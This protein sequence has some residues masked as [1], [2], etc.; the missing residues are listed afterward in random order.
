MPSCLRAR[1]PPRRAIQMTTSRTAG[2]LW[3]RGLPLLAKQGMTIIGILMV[4]GVAVVPLLIAVVVGI[5]LRHHGLRITGILLLVLLGAFL[6][7]FLRPRFIPK[8]SDGQAFTETGDYH[9]H[10]EYG[11]P[12]GLWRQFDDP[13]LN[14]L[15]HQVDILGLVVDGILWGYCVVVAAAPGGIQ[16]F[17][18]RR[19]GSTANTA[20]HGTLASSRP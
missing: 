6:I 20:S 19:R 12:F 9:D 5:K 18:R 8:L 16:L 2:V 17:R 10:V 11:W 15:H 13:E 14:T 7:L 1:K 3:G 4:L